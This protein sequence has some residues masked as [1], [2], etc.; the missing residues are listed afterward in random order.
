MQEILTYTLV[1]FAFSFN[2]DIFSKEE[3]IN[4][5]KQIVIAKETVRN[6]VVLS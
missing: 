5:A 3:K 2:K 6:R 4:A 1:A